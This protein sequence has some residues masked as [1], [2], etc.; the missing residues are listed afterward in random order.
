MRHAICPTGILMCEKDGTMALFMFWS[1]CWC[2]QVSELQRW[3]L[4]QI[5]CY[6]NKRHSALQIATCQ[7]AQRCL[8]GK[9]YGSHLI[10]GL[11]KRWNDKSLIVF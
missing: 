2:C 11:G 9:G 8:V 3:P 6:R 7:Q 4:V 1:L 10:F 5:Y